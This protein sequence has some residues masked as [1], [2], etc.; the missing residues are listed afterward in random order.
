MITMLDIGGAERLLVDILPLMRDAGHDVEL[1][2]FDGVDTPFK[3]DLNDK[4][5]RIHK[6]SHGKDVH[7]Y[8]K[9]VYDPYHIIRLRKYIHGYDIIHTHNSICQFYVAIAHL[10]NRSSTP[11]VTTEHSS[12]NRRR[13]KKWFKPIDKW[14]YN[15]YASI[16]CIAEKTKQNLES[17]IG[18]NRSICT[19]NNG[20]DV[21]RFTRPIK[22]VSK[23]EKYN[24]TMVAGLRAEKDHE[25]IIKSMALLPSYYHLFLVGDG[26]RD[27]ELK[28]FTKRHSLSDKVTFTGPRLD[29]PDLLEK[30][31][32]VVLSS[33]WEGL[34]LSSIEGMASGRPFIASDVDGLREIVDGAGVLFPHGDE[35]EL[36]KKIQ[37]LCE[38][39]D[40]YR[41]VAKRCQAR[42]MEY[43]I[44]IMTKKYLDLY[45]SLL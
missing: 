15:Q 45:N 3:R 19:I 31:D 23:Q 1:L 13:T 40:E 29:V 28:D 25:T 30:S 7:N 35:K 34:S 12:N 20:V 9:E 24:V 33:H 27:Q 2:L 42:A 8:Y 16:I 39:P 10:L 44:S 26:V 22:D 32:I 38:H 41:E 37:W 4:G 11:L 6:L 43:D 21:H 18:K 5:I 17:Y 14:M 36:A